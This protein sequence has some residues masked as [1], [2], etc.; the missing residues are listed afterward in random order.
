MGGFLDEFLEYSFFTSVDLKNFRGEQTKRDE[1]GHLRL[2]TIS[3]ENWNERKNEFFELRM[4]SL[5]K[6]TGETKRELIEYEIEKVECLELHRE[7]FARMKRLYLKLLRDELQ[8]EPSYSNELNVFTS[9]E[10]KKLF[11]FLD[12]KWNYSKNTRYTYIYNLMLE[13]GYPLP[14]TSDYQRF[15]REKINHPEHR[16]EL[17][18][19]TSDQRN[20]EVRDLIGSFE[21]N[22][23]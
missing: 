13:K 21:L 10:S 23:N 11:H 22:G 17:D 5:D 2:E 15:I 3:L 20:N 9:E 12:M 16:V 7:S 19:A 1:N 4:R 6:G 18:K 14:Q 8:G